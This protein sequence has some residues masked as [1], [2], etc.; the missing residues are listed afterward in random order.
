MESAKMKKPLVLILLAGFVL[1]CTN[2]SDRIER[3]RDGNGAEIVRNRLPLAG[4]KESASPFDLFEEGSIDTRDA[5]VVTAGLTDIGL[6]DVDSEGN[7][8]FAVPRGGDKALLKFDRRGRFQIAFGRKGKGPGEVQDISHLALTPDNEVAVTDRGSSRLIL[9]GPEGDLRR[10]LRIPT[11]FREVR[12]LGDGRMLLLDQVYSPS[13]DVFYEDRVTL[14]GPDLKALK[15]LAVSSVE[16]PMS[17]ERFK[18]SYHIQSWSVSKDHIFTGNQ[19]SDYEIDVFDFEGR[20][21]RRILKDFDPVSVPESFKTEYL[22]MFENPSN[23]AIRSKVYFPD[24]MPPFVSFITDEEGR[25]Y[26]LTHES[27]PSAEEGIID[28]FAPDGA[29]LGKRPIRVFHD[30]TGMHARVGKGRFYAVWENED[31]YKELRIYR[32]TWK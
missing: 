13:P 15:V 1:A 27:G 10:E 16:N 7:I 25:I 30:F 26:V 28:V 29:F 31:G 4:N 5:S 14:V 12:P 2:R 20:L 21:V 18:G 6:F 11:N 22:K 17:A 24:A 8:Y 19:E 3:T 23:S 32:M 9:Y